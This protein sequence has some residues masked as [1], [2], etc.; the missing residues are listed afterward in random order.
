MTCCGC[1]DEKE[2]EAAGPVDNSAQQNPDSPTDAFPKDS[3]PKEPDA[4]LTGD[5]VQI[6]QGVSPGAGRSS[7]S[8]TSQRASSGKVS[9][10]SEGGHPDKLKSESSKKNTTVTAA[11]ALS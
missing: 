6:E 8:A 4:A 5:T 9:K 11:A 7:R 1:R 3:S 2:E 10:G